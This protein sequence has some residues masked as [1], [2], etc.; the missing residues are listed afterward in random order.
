VADVSGDGLADVAVGAPNTP[1]NAT[2][3]SM[4]TAYVFIAQ[5]SVT[6]GVTGWQ[7]HTIQAPSVD[8]DF[9]A[10]GWSTAAVPGSSLIF[11]GEHGRNVGAT[12]FAG[13]VYVYR[14]LP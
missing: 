1:D 3:N 13:Q 10:F 6:T 8:P 2:C 12:S 11:I 9:A 7:R 4:G 5:G 14:V